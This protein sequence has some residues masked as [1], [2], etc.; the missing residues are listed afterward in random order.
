MVMYK[1]A[2]QRLPN[3]LVKQYQD[4]VQKI[5]WQKSQLQH[6]GPA[7]RNGNLTERSSLMD[8]A[9]VLQVVVQVNTSPIQLF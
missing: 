4:I 8:P 7:V 5:Q 6:G 9:P 2:G 3:E 1:Q